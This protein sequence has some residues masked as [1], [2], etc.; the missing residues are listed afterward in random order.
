MKGPWCCLCEGLVTLNASDTR[1]PHSSMSVHNLLGTL[2]TRMHRQINTLL[3]AARSDTR[4][5][6]KNNTTAQV[7]KIHLPWTEPLAQSP[8]R[9]TLHL[10]ICRCL[11]KSTNSRLLSVKLAAS[12]LLITTGRVFSELQEP[13]FSPFP[14]LYMH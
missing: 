3:C 7:L 2:K 6:G 4:Y 8:H 12:P 13:V 14:S 11:R 9:H 1:V 10:P 5:G